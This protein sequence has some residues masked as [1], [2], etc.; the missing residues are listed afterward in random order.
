MERVRESLV[1]Q[2]LPPTL[3]TPLIGRAAEVGAVGELLCRGDVRLATLCGA[4][5]IGKTRIAL[6]VAATLADRFSGGVHVVDL[7]PL[8]DPA[9]VVPTIATRLGVRDAGDQPILDALAAT[10]GERRMLLVLDNFEHVLEAA[11]DIARL[12][13]SCPN[14]TLLTTSRSL[15]R[16]YGEC[17]VSVPPLALPVAAVNGSPAE[18]QACASVELFVQRARAARADFSLSRTTT[19]RPWR[20]SVGTWTECRWRSSWPPLG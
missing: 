14:L 6:A 7:A 19:W 11:T 16:V 1:A 3:S 13:D 15:L 17:P 12:L 2:P 8:S 10:I 4:G 20:T 18:L 5:G 9:T